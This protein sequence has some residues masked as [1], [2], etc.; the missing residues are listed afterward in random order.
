MLSTFEEMDYTHLRDVIRRVRRRWRL[1]VLL[2]GTAL[3]SLIGFATLA[4]LS[5]S[6]D[7][8]RYRPWALTT[9]SVLIYA[10]LLLLLVRFFV[11]P[12]SRRVADDR[13]A[14][15]IEEHEPELQSEILSAVEF[16]SAP[17]LEDT[18]ERSADFT[19]E[20]ISNAVMHCQNLQ[21]GRAVERGSL[22][23]F[24][25]AV[26][27]VA[28]FLLVIALLSPAFLRNGAS[29]LL[30]PWTSTAFASP[31]RMVNT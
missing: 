25:T 7:Y 1:R 11:L 20:L 27:A 26:A 23:R 31:G 21:Y 17:H 30:M 9:F 28:A 6:L 22:R 29:L 13:V 3:V 14:L 16:A 19:R 15:Y 12:L 8:L 10:V 18:P 4:I 24:A 2:E 5:Y